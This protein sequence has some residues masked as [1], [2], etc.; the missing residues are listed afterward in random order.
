MSS[1]ASANWSDPDAVEEHL[2]ASRQQ[3]V[4]EDLES[5]EQLS[6]WQKLQRERQQRTRE[7]RV[8]GVTI[9]MYPLGGDPIID[10]IEHEDAL[11]DEDLDA[12][13]SAA[14]GDGGA[15][16]LA[17]AMESSSDMGLFLD[18]IYTILAEYSVDE[19]M[20]RERWGTV[21]PERAMVA[22][23]Q[24][25]DQDAALTEEEVTEYAEFRRE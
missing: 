10:A 19:S 25:T 20:T 18:T 13:E 24:W 11:P 21:P 17:Q 12:I 8:W 22:F 1:V 7:V 6:T 2:E 14:A 5:L 15:E 23:E 4:E 9:E 16:E 3:R